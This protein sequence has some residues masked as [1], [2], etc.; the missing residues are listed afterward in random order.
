M[1]ATTTT[2][3]VSQNTST[4]LMMIG[5]LCVLLL[6]LLRGDG[7]VCI[8]THAVAGKRSFECLSRDRVNRV[9]VRVY[10]YG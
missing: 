8:R 5:R 3:V 1:N 10:V 7:R 6:L 2:E 4:I 9:Y